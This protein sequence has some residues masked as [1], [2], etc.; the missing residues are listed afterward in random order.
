MIVFR[1]RKIAIQNTQRARHTQMHNRTADGGFNNQ[2]LGSTMNRENGLP[3][4]LFQLLRDR[5]AQLGRT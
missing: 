1:G 5:P 3:F 4:K 2:I